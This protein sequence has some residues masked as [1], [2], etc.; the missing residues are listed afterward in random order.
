MSSRRVLIPRRPVVVIPPP[1]P[2]WYRMPYRKAL[3]IETDVNEWL[4]L[5]INSPEPAPV[6]GSIHNFKSF[7]IDDQAKVTI[8]IRRFQVDMFS[9]FFGTAA[10]TLCSLS[11]PPTIPL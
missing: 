3:V 4:K 8:R 5:I 9:V 10:D 1:P 7:G 2:D 11:L 6:Q